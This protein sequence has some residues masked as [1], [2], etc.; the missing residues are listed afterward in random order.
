[1]ACAWTPP[2]V[3]SEFRAA[4]RRHDGKK[5]D[6]KDQCRSAARTS[7]NY[8]R[9]SPPRMRSSSRRC[10]APRPVHRLVAGP[11]TPSVSI[12]SAWPRRRS[13]APG[14]WRSLPEGRSGLWDVTF[15][16]AVAQA[17]LESRISGLLPQDSLPFRR[18][19]PIYIETTR[20]NC[21]TAALI[22]HRMTTV[23]RSISASTSTPLFHV[24]V[25]ILAQRAAEMDKGAASPCAARS[26]M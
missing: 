10:G 23:T 26:A 22:A 8:A 20:P 14:P 1:M 16:T 12:R 3:R 15:Q 19:H 21:Y 6:A 2:E 13:C 25:P 11:T 5:I 18:W 4:V 7:S 17:E 9:S 24:K